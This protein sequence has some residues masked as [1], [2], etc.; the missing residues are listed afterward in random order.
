MQCRIAT[1][2]PELDVIQSF[3]DR[4]ICG[5]R[6]G[7]A[8]SIFHEPRLET[9]YPDLVFVYWDRA[10]ADG[11][12]VSRTEL[13]GG[14]LRLLQY[15]HGARSL[16]RA[17]IRSR[18]NRL[19]TE[20]SIDRLSAAGTVKV[21]SRSIRIKPLRE[22]FAV[23]RII[24]LEAKIKDWRRGLQQA[25]LNTWFASE[26]FLLLP[27]IPAAGSLTDDAAR[28]GVG[29]LSADRSLSTPQIRS[30]RDRL[31]QS[32]A[33]WLFNEWVWRGFGRLS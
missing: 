23:R 11:W 18:Q 22:I 7:C 17:E 31:P 28:L 26:S 20:R 9:G 16:S 1:K 24:A 8:L 27:R 2:G 30:R 5:H 29:V 4:D 21:S 33:S 12:P 6:G 15:I 3:L 10:A 13:T 19:E 14:D 25:F 32:Y